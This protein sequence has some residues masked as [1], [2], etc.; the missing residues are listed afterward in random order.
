MGLVGHSSQVAGRFLEGLH[1]LGRL[2][3]IGSRLRFRA[4]FEGGNPRCGFPLRLLGRVDRHRRRRETLGDVRERALGPPQSSSGGADRRRGL[5]GDSGAVGHD[6]A[7]VRGIRLDKGGER[8]R[9]AFATVDVLAERLE[10]IECRAC[11][12]HGV[13]IQ[14]GQGMDELLGQAPRIDVLPDLRLPQP[15]KEP[16]QGFILVQGQAEEQRAHVLAVVPGVVE[17]AARPRL[18]LERCGERRLAQRARRV[19]QG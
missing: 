9:G 18:V 4:L 14:G 3:E 17:D 15:V 8:G 16:E 11:C 13:A 19:L 1:Q 12:A 2:R 7:G 10:F 5:Q 6:G